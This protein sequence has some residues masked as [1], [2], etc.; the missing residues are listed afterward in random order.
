MNRRAARFLCV[1]SLVLCLPSC[2]ESTNPLSDP[3]DAMPDAALFGF[4]RG[5]KENEVL[6]IGRAAE[7]K[8]REDIPGGIMRL[9]KQG[10]SDE[11]FVGGAGSSF[12]F[13]THLG[14]ASYLNIMSAPDQN[15][16]NLEK[17]NFWLVKYEV[18]GDK[19]T[20]WWMGDKDAAAKVIDA[21]T[22]RGT[23]KRDDDD[24]KVSSIKFTDTT[25]NLAKYFEKNGASFYP[26]ANKAEYTRIGGKR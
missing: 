3:K 1:A 10:I 15:W 12:C 2:I 13:V 21:G 20:I 17:D 25:A 4:W 14:K 6:I 22:L 7:L 18:S 11:N 9:I 16:D 23:V 8:D 26:E 19:L 24:K 5:S